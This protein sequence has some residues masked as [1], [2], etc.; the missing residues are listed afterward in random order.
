MERNVCEFLF[1][2]FLFL[3]KKRNSQ[4]I[5]SFLNFEVNFLFF[6][7]LWGLSTCNNAYRHLLNFTR[8]D[9]QP[10]VLLGLGDGGDAPLFRGLFNGTHFG[11]SNLIQIYGYFGRI[12]LVIVHCLQWMTPVDGMVQIFKAP[13][14]SGWPNLCLQR[15]ALLWDDETWWFC[16][17]PKRHLERFAERRGCERWQVTLKQFLTNVWRRLCL[18]MQE[19][20]CFFI[21]SANSSAPS[22]NTHFATICHNQSTNSTNIL[23]K[24]KG[25][26]AY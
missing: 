19:S 23:R 8:P 1:F 20:T 22:C 9:L 7:P 25:S 26:R 11:G 12:S 2:C 14:H 6:F 15:V 3:D 16:N 17:Q 5:V 18:S 13:Y 10:H 21:R 24:M 4:K